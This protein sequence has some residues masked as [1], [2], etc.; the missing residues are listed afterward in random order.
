M[1][2]VTRF[3]WGWPHAN[4]KQKREIASEIQKMIERCLRESLRADG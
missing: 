2:V 4:L 1:D 3:K